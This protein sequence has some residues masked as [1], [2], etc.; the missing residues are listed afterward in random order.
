MRY[1]SLVI[2]L[3]SLSINFAHSSLLAENDLSVPINSPDVSSITEENFVNLLSKMKSLYIEQ[4]PRDISFNIY[5]EWTNAEVYAGASRTYSSSRK[6]WSIVVSGGIAR[7]PLMT[8]DGLALVVCHEWG[9]YLGGAPAE[10]EE[11]PSIGNNAY[12]SQADYFATLKC[13][14]KFWKNDN[15]IEVIAGLEIPVTLKIKCLTAWSGGDEA[16]CI[17]SGLAGLS[18]ARV[19]ADADGNQVSPSFDTPD[20]SRV[21]RTI[22]DY[23]S[24]QCRLDTFLEGAL[25]SASLDEMVSFS[26]EIIGTC[27]SSLGHQSGKRPSCWFK[28]S[29]I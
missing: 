21:H 11:Y 8:L 26:S 17:R 15:N 14:R 12:E 16:L 4:V 9:H 10:T 2:L 27:H 6:R 5:G 20:R 7:H 23:P 25:C 24:D 3:S 18:L 1:L 28:E 19:I 13:L 22:Q 29:K